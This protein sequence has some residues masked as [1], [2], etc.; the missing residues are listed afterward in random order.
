V[1]LGVA[2]LALEALAQLAE[3]LLARLPGTRR[4]C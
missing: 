1:A 4:D 2:V 3:L